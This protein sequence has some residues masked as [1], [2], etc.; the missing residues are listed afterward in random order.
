MRLAKALVERG[1]H[2]GVEWLATGDVLAVH[3]RIGERPSDLAA[4]LDAAFAS[5]EDVDGAE[6]VDRDGQNRDRKPPSVAA[7]PRVRVLAT[8]TVGVQRFSTAHTALLHHSNDLFI[9]LAHPLI[10][11]QRDRA[12]PDAGGAR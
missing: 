11:S 9:R 5:V 1:K 12:I 6:C 8:Y 7:V 2:L 10:V 4:D 3:K